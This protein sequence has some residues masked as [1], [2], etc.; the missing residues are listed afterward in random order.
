MAARRPVT[1][2]SDRRGRD[3]TRPLRQSAARHDTEQRDN[4]ACSPDGR[5]T[6]RIAA[7]GADGDGVAALPSGAAVH[8]PLTLPGETVQ[9]RLGP[10]TGKSSSGVVEQVLTPSPER[11]AA[12]CPRFGSCGGCSLQHWQDA[13]YAAW[14]SDLVAAA[15]RRAGYAEFSLAPLMRTPPGGRRRMD[16]AFRRLSDGMVVGLHRRRTAEIVDIAPCQVLDP[17]LLALLAPLRR[18]LPRLAGVRREGSAVANLLDDAT[19]LLLRTD[20]PLCAADRTALA[21]F[22][23]EAGIAR[24]SWSRGEGPPETACLLRPPRVTFSGSVVEPPPG[25]FLQASVAGEAAIRAAV[26]AGLPS[27]MGSRPRIVELFA[28]CGTLSFALAGRGRVDA[29]EGDAAACAAL[30]RAA[31]G[32]RITVTQR[33]LA[34]QPLAAAEF[35]GSSAVVL[36]PPYAGAA[37]QMPLIAAARVPRVIYVSCNPAALARDAGVLHA[38]GYAR[39]A[40]TPIDQFLWS[41][42]VE[43]VTVFRL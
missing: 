20:A 40:A 16:L 28:G 17:R 3:G 4:E 10:R 14:K 5:V 27:R 25:A 1:R 11:V 34:R 8:L 6:L 38:A 36:D 19:D 43:S 41:S 31:G 37:M 15:L 12:P 22:A 35:A 13:N 30:R 18:L 24:I 2:R 9:A 42:R 23:A 29:F 39:A 32:T 33:D 26:L 21:R 7:I